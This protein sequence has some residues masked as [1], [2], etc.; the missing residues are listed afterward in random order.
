[1][2]YALNLDKGTNAE[3]NRIVKKVIESSTVKAFEREG[4]KYYAID[5]PCII[6]DYQ[7]WIG[8]E[9]PSKILPK[10]LREYFSEGYREY[11]VNPKNLRNKDLDLFD[12]IRRIG[13]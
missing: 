13:K 12:F 2:Y 11:F 8:T 10:M 3:Y 4:V 5:G 9:K 7:G 1:M 6:S